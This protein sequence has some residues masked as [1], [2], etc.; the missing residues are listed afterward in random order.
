MNSQSTNLAQ[1]Q[2]V[3]YKQIKMSIYTHP[4]FIA[5]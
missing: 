5:K 4:A 2:Q 3:G 1:I